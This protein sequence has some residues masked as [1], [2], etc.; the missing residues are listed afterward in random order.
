M[1]EYA[2]NQTK[3]EK[4]GILEY[5]HNH[6]PKFFNDTNG[7]NTSCVKQILKV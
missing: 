6:L 2:I 5:H 3:S 7:S 4:S 1:V